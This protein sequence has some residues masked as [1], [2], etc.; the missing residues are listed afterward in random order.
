MER[1]RACLSENISL[2]QYFPDEQAALLNKGKREKRITLNSLTEDFVFNRG[3]GIPGSKQYKTQKL[4]CD[5]GNAD[6]LRLLYSKFEAQN[7]E[8]FDTI[9]RIG[10]NIVC[11]SV[12]LNGYHV[13]NIENTFMFTQINIT[14][15]LTDTNN[16]FIKFENNPYNDYD[17]VRSISIVY[18]PK[19]R[20]TDLYLRNRLSDNLAEVYADVTV[21]SGDI[22][23]A[24]GGM[25]TL[26][27]YDRKNIIAETTAPVPAFQRNH[28]TVIRLSFKLKTPRLWSIGDPH[29]YMLM[30]KYHNADGTISDIR[31]IKHGIREL[32]FDR[33]NKKKNKG[34]E[35]CVNGFP[36]KIIGAVIRNQDI[37]LPKKL[38][39]AGF[40]AVRVINPN[41]MPF[42]EACENEGLLVMSEV[43]Y[44]LAAG[45]RRKRK[46]ADLADPLSYPFALTGEM[47]THL[48]N[49][50][51]VFCW[52][53]GGRK[54][55]GNRVIGEFIRS[56]DDTRAV[57]C[58]GDTFFMISDFFSASDCGLDEMSAIAA[59]RTVS[60]GRFFGTRIRFKEYK[61]H[62]LLLCEADAD[63]EVIKEKFV[64]ANS[65]EGI[66]GIF[67]NIEEDGNIDSLG[68]FINHT[69]S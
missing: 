48:K 62:P 14:D 9:L 29:R 33:Y 11:A 23:A 50:A 47:I 44:G 5:I 20:I 27:V 46:N 2:G 34:P 1:F 51:S 31:I 63:S 56:M 67:I 49:H 6:E 61:N 58:E 41:S 13:A 57:N 36:V 38:K 45:K 60:D 4:P 21:V 8:G 39:S 65:T 30:L 7:E 66:L 22:S 52:S 43:K 37:L 10:G 25:V 18:L 42:L 55:F 40:N 32:R 59:R 24:L 12:Y 68:E 28:W 17:T 64:F 53:I 16:L 3:V 15:Y 54:Y 26:S 69:A 35:F 19:S